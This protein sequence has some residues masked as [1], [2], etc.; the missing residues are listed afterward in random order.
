MFV[1]I[2]EVEILENKKDEYLKIASMLKEQLVKEKGFVS[3]ERFQSLVDENKLLSLS[4]WESEDAILNWKKI[5]IMFL[6]KKKV[7]NLFLKII[8]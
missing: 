2:F 8:K 3:I 6:L 4:F 1:V 7:E 5:W